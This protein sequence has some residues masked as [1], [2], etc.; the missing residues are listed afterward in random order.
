M[1]KTILIV[2]D[3]QPL[4]DA[5]ED[6]LKKEGFVA[7]IAKNGLEAVEVATAEKP[8][9]ILLD[10]MMPGKNG[11]DVLQEIRQNIGIFQTPVIVLTNLEATADIEK[12]LEMGATTY[13]VKATYSLEE[14]VGKI[15]KTLGE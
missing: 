11:L 3:E 9:L 13:L 1:A 8:D 10:L 5:L 12:A 15:K 4:R 7:L 6:K 14:V 2:E